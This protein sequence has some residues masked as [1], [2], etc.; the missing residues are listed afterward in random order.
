MLT[1]NDTHYNADDF[2]QYDQHFSSMDILSTAENI[3]VCLA[4]NIA[5]LALC[6]Y[7]QKHQLSVMPIHPSVPLNTAKNAA[8]KAG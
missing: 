1:I 7:A 6:A 4:D 2:L 3:A 8:A 5:W